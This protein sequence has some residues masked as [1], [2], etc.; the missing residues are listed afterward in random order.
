M[1]CLQYTEGASPK[2]RQ[3]VSFVRNRVTNLENFRLKNGKKSGE[4]RLEEV[5]ILQKG[6][7]ERLPAQAALQALKEI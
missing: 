1:N 5:S 3:N 6:P 7:L 4:L 2:C